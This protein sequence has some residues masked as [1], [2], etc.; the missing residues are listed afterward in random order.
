MGVTHRSLVISTNRA[1]RIIDHA[2]GNILAYYSQSLTLGGSKTGNVII[3]PSGNIGIGTT[4]PQA[5]FSVG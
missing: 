3:N 4:N 2:S 5:L 1:N